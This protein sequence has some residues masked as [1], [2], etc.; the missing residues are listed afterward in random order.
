MNKIIEKTLSII[1][2][3]IILLTIIAILWFL[4]GLSH[5]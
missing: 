3:S 1:S 4:W 5:I 2:V